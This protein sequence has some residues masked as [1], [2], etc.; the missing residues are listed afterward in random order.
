MPD[1]V[2][3]STPRWAA[4]ALRAVLVVGLLAPLLVVVAAAAPVA[5]TVGPAVGPSP[6]EAAG[7]RSVAPFAGLGSWVD[8]YDWS[9]TYTGGRPTVGLADI[10]RMAAL[11]VTTLYI[12]TASPYRSEDVLERTRLQAL[13]DR[14]HARG[15]AV[16]GWYV[17]SLL[18]PAADLRRVEAMVPLGVDGIG[19][20]VEDK[21]VG[22][23]AERNR[24]L[25]AFSSTLRSRLPSVPLSAVTLD[26][27][28]LDVINPSYWPNFPW[29]QL[30]PSYDVWQPM[31][32][33]SGRTTSSGYRDGYRY[34]AENI[35]RIRAHVGRSD[36]PVHPIG[37][38]ANLITVAD[39]QGMILAAGERN[40]LGISLYDYTIT[41]P[42][43]WDAL[44]L[45]GGDPVGNLEVAGPGPRSLV[46]SGWALDPDTTQPV[47]VH[48][49]VD[50]VGRANVAADLTRSDI[51]G[52]FAGW[53]PDHGFQV[54]VGDLAPGAHQVCV[55]A[56]SLGRG[57]NVQLGCRTV[58]VPTGSPVGA[59]EAVRPGLLS[60]RAVGFALDPDVQ[61]PTDVHLYLDGVGRANIPTDVARPDLYG[62][63]PGWTD[64]GFS[65]VLGDVGPGVHELCAFAINRGAGQ[66]VLLGC[67]SAT[68][69]PSP[70]GVLEQVRVVAPGTVQLSG[71]AIDPDSPQP[72][73]VHVYVDG[74]GRANIPADLTRTDLGAIYPASGADHG[75]AL[76]L[77]AV[78]PGPHQVCAY[79]INVGPGANVK[80]GCR[81]VTVPTGPPVGALDVVEVGPGALRLA[82][83][84]LDPDT[85]SPVRV[86][87]Y[88][89]GVGRASIPADRPRGDI[90]RAFPGWGAYHGFD[91]SISGLGGGTHQ[92]CAYA[93]DLVPG[94]GHTALGCRTVSAVSGSPIG[95]VESV[96]SAG[97]GEARIIGWALDPDT[98]DPVD[99]HVYVDG[100]GAANVPADG[101]RPDVGAFFVLWGEAH[102]VDVTVGG[103][104]PGPRQVCVFAIDRVAP[105]DNVLLRCAM[106]DVQ[107]PPP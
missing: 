44:R 61:G 75:F 8:M 5:P 88:V 96:A 83:W 51:A 59:L 3:T 18:D 45:S 84:A 7:G 4:R 10:D 39:L 22:D 91:H 68:V 55:Y 33:W 29:A 31:A 23:H 81:A 56:I 46:V 95:N 87:V 72:L 79:A 98:V 92:V 25:I 42:A 34:I 14:A 66:N 90:G 58:V 30:A 69:S 21:A 27:V 36:Y 64:P 41:P 99:V 9:N 70:G 80:L 104:D 47:N 97:P 50:G 94:V 20:D 85:P 32:Y 17:P 86:H 78:G 101:S 102:G 63:Y 43:I 76:E 65:H 37:G 105:G 62:R 103:L 15:V 52:R 100:V 93:I 16:V 24:R 13:I 57:H 26:A 28:H 49:Y 2:P 106:V 6:A 60:V 12:Q 71:W 19:I 74:V 48:V 1:H 54:P 82:G 40:A 89:D 107:A 77:G 11:G 73:D 67:R 53:G 38:L 35:D